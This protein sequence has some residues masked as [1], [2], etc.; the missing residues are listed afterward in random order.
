M[1]FSFLILLGCCL[2]FPQAQAVTKKIDDLSYAMGYQIGASLKHDKFPLDDDGFLQGLHSGYSGSKP[3][4]SHK[5]MQLVINQ[6]QMQL[7]KENQEKMQKL[8][9]ANLAKGKAF[10]NKNKRAKGVK[11]LPDGLQYKI[12]QAGTGKKPSATDTVTVDYEGKLIDGMI[13]DSSFKR[14]K[15]AQFKVNQVIPGWTKA[16]QMMPEGS[17]WM[18]FIPANLAYGKSETGPIPPNSVL[19]FKVHLIKID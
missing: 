13:F 12:I 1:K 6:F 17:T 19:I 4:I 5:K 8:S 7:I 16:L 9:K 10:L 11:T 2:L 15:P 3:V 14:G 18:L